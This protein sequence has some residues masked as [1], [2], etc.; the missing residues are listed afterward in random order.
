MTHL[1]KIEARA[2]L[3]VLAEK[4]RNFEF[5][6]SKFYESMVSK[7]AWLATKT[8]ASPKVL[9]AL[10]TATDMCEDAANVLESILV[11]NA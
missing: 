2:E 11:K 7:S 6:L 10:E 8:C 1:D 9:S 5:G 4:R 3:L